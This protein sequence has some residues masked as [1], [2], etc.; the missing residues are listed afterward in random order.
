MK[1]EE[2]HQMEEGVVDQEPCVYCSQLDCIAIDTM[3]ELCGKVEAVEV[4]ISYCTN[5]LRA[6]LVR[7]IKILRIT[8]K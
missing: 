5:C 2:L 7:E 1:N 8:G 3:N 6:R 4:R